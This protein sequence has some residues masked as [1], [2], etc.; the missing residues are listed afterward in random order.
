MFLLPNVWNLFSFTIQMVTVL[1]DPLDW[2]DR[3]KQTPWISPSLVQQIECSVNSEPRSEKTRDPFIILC[4]QSILPVLECNACP[5][6]PGPADRFTCRCKPS[7]YVSSALLTPNSSFSKVTLL[8]K[9]ARCRAVI[10]TGVMSW[11]SCDRGVN[12]LDHGG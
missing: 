3:F 12:L 2:P 10:G 4:K 8:F 1:T 11:C 7:N 5:H 6:L 9:A